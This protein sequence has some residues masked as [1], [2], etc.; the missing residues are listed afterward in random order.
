MAM[1][2]VETAMQMLQLA[3]AELPLKSPEHST[4]LDALSKLSKSFNRPKSQDMVPAQIQ[5]M[6][7]SQQQSGVAQ[8]MAQ[9]G[10]APAPGGQP[11]Q[12]PMPPMQ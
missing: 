12:P 10:G 3:M 5:E 1:V 2:R 9:G 4:V 11:P 6:A 8:M 7:R